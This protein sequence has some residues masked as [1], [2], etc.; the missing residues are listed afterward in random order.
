MNRMPT[1][2]EDTYHVL[3]AYREAGRTLVGHLIGRY[4]QE[5]SIVPGK[6]QYSGYSGYCRFNAFV[7]DMDIHP[8]WHESKKNPDL[9]TIYLEQR[10]IDLVL[11]QAEALSETWV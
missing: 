4:I 7:E 3:S 1:M 11:Q 8:E 10:A 2:N 6:G 9:I 5:I